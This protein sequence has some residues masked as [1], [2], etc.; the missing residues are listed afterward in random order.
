[1]DDSEPPFVDDEAILDKRHWADYSKL[2][3]F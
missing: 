3:N 2:A 1:M